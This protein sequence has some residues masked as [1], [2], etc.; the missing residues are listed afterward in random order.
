MRAPVATYRLQ[1]TPEHGFDHACALVSYLAELGVSHIYLSPIAEAAEG[2]QHGYDVTDPNRVRAALGGE[3]GLR[4]LAR[5]A[6]E[7]GLSLL[8]DIVPNHVAADEA[9]PWWWD[10]LTHGRDAAHARHF[11]I[12][13]EPTGG[14]FHGRLVLG[15]LDDHYGRVLG[16]GDLQLELEDQTVVL[17]WP[18]GRLPLSPETV[19]HIQDQA[20]VD[21]VN[22]DRAAL[23]EILEA[24]HHILMRWQRGAEEIDY[25]RFFDQSHLVGVRVE[26]SDVFDDAHSTFLR[27]HAEGVIDGFRIDH[28]DGLR[29]PA[30]YLARLRAAAPEA[31]IVVE[32]ILLGDELLPAW[33][34][35]GTTGYDAM[36]VVNGLGIEPSGWAHLVDIWREAAAGN[37]WVDD[38]RLQ[39]R[40]LVLNTT[41]HAEVTRC[42]DLFVEACEASLDHRDFT[43]RELAAALR[44]AAACTPTYRTYVVPGESPA[45]FDVEVV[46]RGLTDAA[47]L[48]PT[49]DADLWTFLRAILLGRVPGAGAELAARYQ[50]LTGPVAAKG[51]EDTLS[52]RWTPLASAAEVGGEVGDPCRSPE[53]LHSWAQATQATWP[54]AL[55]SLTTHDTK[56]SEDVRAR[57]AVMSQDSDHVV[58]FFA[59]VDPKIDEGQGDLGLRWLLA[60]TAVAAWPIGADRM[61]AYAEK[62]AREARMVTSWTAPDTRAERGIEAYARALVTDG[63]TVSRIEALMERWGQA[64]HDQSLAQKAVALTLPGVPDVYQGAEL[65]DLRLVDPDNRS[66]VDFDERQ[67]LM[68]SGDDPK[69]QLVRAILALRRRQ[70]ACFGPGEAGAHMPIQAPADMVAFGRGTEVVV[71]AARFSWSRR[72]ESFDPDRDVTLPEGAWF[73]VLSGRRVFGGA[74]N[75][76]AV[77]GNAAVVVLERV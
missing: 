49:V 67:R 65:T 54:L 63:H 62:A 14:R 6:D 59:E 12:D 76:G 29:D 5:V 45:P 4:R 30:G 66:P 22:C 24:Q 8:V 21:A 72:G 64:F 10:V 46:D 53:E 39:C 57:M 9:N 17:R 68:A 16:R 48:D 47:E 3:A 55:V 2:S 41:L 27:L 58:R 61:A 69:L 33:P 1:L 37:S 51:D 40:Q 43:R 23:H 20:G 74:T 31:W 34:I 19:S 70:A 26:D 15:V 44:A 7:A 38:V 71:F 52:Y 50:Q 32:K 60:Q 11:D 28:I 56:R 25:R 73:D 77:L 75:V 13:W 36:T 18:A 42:A 35:E